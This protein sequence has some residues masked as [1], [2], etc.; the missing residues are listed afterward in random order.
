MITGI[1]EMHYRLR[2]IK[3]WDS[4]FGTYAGSL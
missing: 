1:Y 2:P 4:S 3:G